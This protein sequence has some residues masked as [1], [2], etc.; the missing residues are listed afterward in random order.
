MAG[1]ANADCG[2]ATG[3]DIWNLRSAREHQRERSRPEC[4]RELSRDSRP[5]GDASLR[6]VQTGHVNDDRVMGRPTLG[7]ENRCHRRRV[8]RVRR[9]A[10]DRLR[11]E[12]H[13]L[14]CAQLFRRALYGAGEERRRMGRQDLRLRF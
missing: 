13:Q 9:K 2:P 8:E 14:A 7:G 6:H 11:W 10:I 1:P 3:Y 5:S 4:A 12:S